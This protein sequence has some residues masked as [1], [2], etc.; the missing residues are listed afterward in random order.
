[1]KAYAI[2]YKHPKHLLVVENNRIFCMAPSHSK[3]SILNKGL[4]KYKGI[5]DSLK[6]LP[7]GL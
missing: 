4:P 3:Y 1:M 2:D 6:Q 5:P 7:I